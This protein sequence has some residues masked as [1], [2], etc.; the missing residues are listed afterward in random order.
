MRVSRVR[1]AATWPILS[2]CLFW[3]FQNA[4]KMTVR[5]FNFFCSAP[6]LAPILLGPLLGFHLDFLQIFKTQKQNAPR[7]PDHPAGRGYL[8]RGFNP[9]PHKTLN[10]AGRMVF[11]VQ[12]NPMDLNRYTLSASGRDPR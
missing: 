11:L 1:N 9:R 12:V 10:D 5:V 4:A 7:G 6:T 3:G 2:L 8:C